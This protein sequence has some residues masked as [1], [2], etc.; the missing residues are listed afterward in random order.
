MLDGVDLTGTELRWVEF[1]GL[2]LKDTQFARDANHLIVRRIK[3]FSEALLA[4]LE[5]SSSA[6]ARF[7]R[8]IVPRRLRQLGPQ[9]AVELFNLKDWCESWDESGN[10]EMRQ[11]FEAAERRCEEAS[12]PD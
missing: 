11:A 7:A 10:A 4:H 1:D 8:E 12:A 2:N 9:Q 3:C 6:P 5:P